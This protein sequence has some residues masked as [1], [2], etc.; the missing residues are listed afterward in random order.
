MKT[1]QAHI[2][3]VIHHPYVKWINDITYYI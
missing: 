3:S 2:M 1:K